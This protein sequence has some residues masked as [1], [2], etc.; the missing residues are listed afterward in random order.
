[1]NSFDLLVQGSML[2][3]FY[4]LVATPETYMGASTVV[5]GR[6]LMT[7]AFKAA[8][9]IASLGMIW[10]A[11]RKFPRVAAFI[12]MIAI[13]MI[14]LPGCATIGSMP[15]SPDK[16]YITEVSIYGG[17]FCEKHRTRTIELRQSLSRCYDIGYDSDSCKK[18]LEDYRVASWRYRSCHGHHLDNNILTNPANFYR[19]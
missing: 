9:I 11:I 5:V 1:M 7:V 16:E 13:I 4:K 8:T 6:R 12:V 15:K 14:T 2:Q 18:K 17:D 10:S 3:G 19:R